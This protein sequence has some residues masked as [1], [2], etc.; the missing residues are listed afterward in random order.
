MVE[1]PEVV[2]GELPIAAD[3]VLLNAADNLEVAAHCLDVE[4]DPADVAEEVIEV[5]RFRVERRE[6]IAVIALDLGGADEAPVLAVEVLVVVVLESRHADQC[7][8]EVIGPAVVGTHE[9][10]R[11][12]FLGPADGV[13]AM[14]A[15]V[16]QDVEAA[17]LVPDDNNAVLA[18]VAE[19]EIARVGD[20]RL[21]AHEVPG[22]GED[23]LELE[24]VDLLVGENLSLDEAFVAVDEAKEVV[25]TER[26]GGH[27]VRLSRGARL[28]AP[29]TSCR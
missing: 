4:T 6:N 20:L 23:V 13:A 29:L 14:A 12:A 17:R 9:G 11:V 16:E 1:V 7:A 27:F 24:L 2:D 15:G 18:D 5:R 19:E 3:D 28:Y 25:G 8:F 26:F 21:V 10:G 22:A